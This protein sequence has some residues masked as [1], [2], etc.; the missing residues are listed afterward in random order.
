LSLTVGRANYR[1]FGASRKQ[2]L[3]HVRPPLPQEM[4]NAV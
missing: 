2:D 1:A 4:S 3:P